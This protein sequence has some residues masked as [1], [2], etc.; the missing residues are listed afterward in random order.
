MDPLGDATLSSQG[1][2]KS[3]P[4]SWTD[5]LGGQTNPTMGFISC[6]IRHLDPKTLKTQKP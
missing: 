1:C 4:L 2:V 5:E 6:T 3:R